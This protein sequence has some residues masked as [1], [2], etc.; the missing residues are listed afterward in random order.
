MTKSILVA[1][2]GSD[3]AERAVAVAA[4]LAQKYDAQLIAVHVMRDTA[5]DARR[6][7]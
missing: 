5:R 4:D 3:N 6:P 7:A 2:D 1:V